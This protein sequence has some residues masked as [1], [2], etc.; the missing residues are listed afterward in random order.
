[1]ARKQRREA[2]QTGEPI[3]AQATDVDVDAYTVSPDG[4]L[5]QRT[6]F[7]LSEAQVERIR[8]GYVCIKC[9]EAYANAFPDA[10]S[11]CHFPMR[12][13]QSDEFA[14]DFR[15]NVRFGPSTTLD[16]E[17]AIAEETIQRDAYDKARK[18]G[19]ILPKYM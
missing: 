9:L 14:K 15:G 11:V 18:L 5:L 6:I 2:T 8:Q 10:C 12:E 16:E 4:R 7:G 19:L 13:R 3:I 1:M 17:Y